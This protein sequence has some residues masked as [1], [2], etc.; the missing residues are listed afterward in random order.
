MQKYVLIYLLEKLEEGT[1]FSA[2]NWPLHVTLA[3]NFIVD[4][5]ATEF[6]IK[7]SDL[8]TSQKPI[9]TTANT[10]EYFGPKKQV[11]VTIL[12]MTPA[13]MTLHTDIIALL[14][15]VGAT[16]DEPHYL[17]A[18]FRAH[19]TVQPHA[20][21]HKADHVT[22]NELTIVDMFPHG[23]INQRKLLQTIKFSGQ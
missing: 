7:L 20:C 10:E 16:F 22:I 8:L 11:K 3:S 15:S 23:D 2:T 17:E 19:A 18:G 5:D 14:K 21:L 13:L 4:W 1:E 12:D 6:F 9:E